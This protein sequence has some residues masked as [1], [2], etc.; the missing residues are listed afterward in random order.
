GL[1]RRVPRRRL[2]RPDRVACRR[3]RVER[4]RRGAG[5]GP[6]CRARA[7]AGP[8]MTAGASEPGHALT[9]GP[10]PADEAADEV[11]GAAGSF[12][13]ERPRLLGL[14]YRMTGSRADA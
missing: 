7:R 6:A 14:A 2:G 1:P 13:H 8:G 9:A 11:A 10:A 5:R 4:R 12:A 3:R